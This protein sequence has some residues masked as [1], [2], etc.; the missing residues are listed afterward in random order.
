MASVKVKR[1][2]HTGICVADLDWSVDF[3]CGV[4]GFELL[5]RAPRQPE[6]QSF[7]TGCPGADVEIAYVQGPGHALELLCY[8]GP[9]DRRQYKPRMVDVGSVHLCLVVDDVEA[10]ASACQ[11]FDSGITT[12]SPRPLVVDAGPNKGNRIIFMQ[13]PDGVTIEFTTRIND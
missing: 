2:F 6:N 5:D 8:S 7:V 11:A 1:V 3:F 13:L 12:L 4:L 9:E 10:A